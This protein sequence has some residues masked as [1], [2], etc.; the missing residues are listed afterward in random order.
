[1]NTPELK[2]ESSAELTDKSE[3][4]ADKNL[5]DSLFIRTQKNFRKILYSSILYIEASGSYCNIH[6][7]NGTQILV[8]FTLTEIMQNLSEYIFIRIHRSFII[9]KEHITGFIGNVFY[10]DEQTIPIGR[11]YKKE[12]LSHFNIL[13]TTC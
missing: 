12:V 6:L 1:M 5:T 10:I 9:N 4:Y 8:A 2:N 11:Q 13:G 3:T 7:D